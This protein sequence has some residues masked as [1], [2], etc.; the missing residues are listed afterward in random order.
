MFDCMVFV[1]MGI[2]DVRIACLH[3]CVYVLAYY[4]VCA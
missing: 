4:L 3:V 2:H 1:D